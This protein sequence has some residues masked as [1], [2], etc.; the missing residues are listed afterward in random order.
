MERRIGRLTETLNQGWERASEVPHSLRVTWTDDSARARVGDAIV[1]S[2]AQPTTHPSSPTI[3]NHQSINRSIQHPPRP[4]APYIIWVSL[5][6][7]ID[8]KPVPEFLTQ[9]RDVVAPPS[10]QPLFLD[11]EDYWERKLWHQ[12]TEALLQFFEHPDSIPQR[13]PIYKNFVLTFSDKI[14][15]LKLVTLGLSASRQCNGPLKR[16][17]PQPRWTRK[18]IIGV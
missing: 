14:N 13:I 4:S 18:L 17:E 3:T 9:Q 1:G 11:F 7:D 6:M 12:L 15:Q 2:D 8:P 16:S 10:L 5:T